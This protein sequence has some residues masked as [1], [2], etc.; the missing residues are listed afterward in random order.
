MN[1]VLVRNDIAVIGMSG[2]FP[3]ASNINEFWENLLAGKSGIEDL[4]EED[5]RA[6]GIPPSIIN[7]PNYVRRAAY[8]GAAK[9]FDAEFFGYSVSEAEML[10]PQHRIFLEHSWAALESACYIPD[11]VPGV[12]GVYASCGFNRYLINKLSFDTK[13]F[14]VDDFQKMVASDKDFLATRV[15]YKLNL[16]GPSISVQSGCSSSLVAVQMGCTALQTYQCDIALC[17]G[18]TLNIPHKAGY[19]YEEGLIFS[20]DGHC[21]AFSNE[22]NGTVF[23]EGVGVVALKRYADAL[24]DGDNIIAVVR[25]AAVNNDGRDKVGYT[26]PSINGQAEVIALALALA[27]IEPSDV[28]FIETHGTGTKL[29][30]PIEIEGLKEAFGDMERHRCALGAVKADI[31]HLDAAAG[32]ASFIKAALVVKHKCIPPMRYAKDINPDLYLEESPFYFNEKSVDFAQPNRRMISGVSS[33]GVGGTNAHVILE[34]PPEAKLDL[35]NRALHYCVVSARNKESTREY[36]EKIGKYALDYPDHLSSLAYTMRQARKLYNHRSFVTLRNSK[37]GVV[38]HPGDVYKV[39]GD[40]KLAFLFSGQ[41]TQYVGM[42]RALYESCKYFREYL[43]SCLEISSQYT[44]VKLDDLLL[45]TNRHQEQSLILNQTECAQPALFIA[46]Y[47]LAKSLMDQGA[48]PCI[49]IGHSLGE[50]VAACIAGVFSLED[51][52]R[53][54]SL[55]GKIMSSCSISGMLMVFADKKSVS[56]HLSGTLQISLLNSPGNTVVSG[57]EAELRHLESRLKSKN[58][59]C[60]HL[61]VSRAF[62]SSYMDPILEE[63]RELLNSVTLHKP[64]IPMVSLYGDHIGV[65]AEVWQA[66][67][68][69]QHLRQPV[70]FIEGSKTLIESGANVHVEIGPGGG[71]LSLVEANCEHGESVQSITTILKESATT[72]QKTIN[73]IL[74]NLWSVGCD[75][76]L[77]R[78]IEKAKFIDAP[79]YPFS[80]REFWLPDLNIATTV[81]DHEASLA[82]ASDQSVRQCV[83]NC[84]SEIFGNQQFTGDENF[85]EM[86][87]DSLLGVRLAKTLSTRL[88]TSINIAQIMRYPTINAF[89]EYFATSDG[90]DK[91][92]G[93]LFPIDKRGSGQPIFLISGAHED[94]YVLGTESSY[95]EDAFRYFST[96]VQNLGGRRP[97]YGFRP[98]GIFQDEEFPQS[99]EEMAEEYIAQIKSIQPDGPYI[100]GGECVGGLVAYE[101]ARQLIQEGDEVKSL[102]LMDTHYPTLGFRISETSRVKLRRLKKSCIE[103][104]DTLRNRGVVAFIQE[105]KRSLTYL[106]VFLFPVT[107]QRHHIRNMLFGSQIYL[108]LLLKYVPS[109]LPM[110]I[111]LLINEEWSKQNPTLDWHLLQSSGIKIE[112]VPGDHKTRLTTYGGELGELIN[113]IIK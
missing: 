92:F 86:G 17:G 101:M 25:S 90:D 26:A 36:Q 31:G 70:N 57:E 12:V 67:Y 33:F 73:E 72:E 15:S 71:L 40:P 108:E 82:P 50:Y 75:I 44:D 5:C 53:L 20:P 60:R 77:D 8:L 100:L 1:D 109:P 51:A 78:M 107:V 68:W 47:S 85:I 35:S 105:A 9:Q 6:A 62:H 18:V 106:S 79:T 99:V 55:R 112:A 97:V 46:E 29:G 91:H 16:K 66:E 110:E 80:R 45:G 4:S 76:S 69:V 58:I 74:L 43:D 23:G 19:C 54:V 28:D 27:D 89:V 14:S 7:R 93:T 39:C 94:R 24:E 84:W 96:L 49:L 37:E 48:D 103:L 21:R 38:A 41:G 63:Y 104:I 113:E 87:G 42:A 10:D 13:N 61:D 34:S 56:D 22:A 81:K 32:I 111:N 98:R 11:E 83:E 3:G 95:E 2:A 65:G 30:D 52:I 59:E 64:T 88:D 102:V